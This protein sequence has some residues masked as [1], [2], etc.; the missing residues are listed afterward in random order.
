MP[1]MPIA[2]IAASGSAPSIVW[3]GEPTLWGVLSAHKG[4]RDYEIR[5][6]GKAASEIAARSAYFDLV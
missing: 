3:V 5:I 2:R 4:I 1:E 6:T